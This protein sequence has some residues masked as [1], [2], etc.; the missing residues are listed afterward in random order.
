MERFK[1]CAH[2]FARRSI[3]GPDAVHNLLVFLFS[4]NIFDTCAHVFRRSLKLAFYSFGTLSHSCSF[5]GRKEVMPFC[6]SHTLILIFPS[7]S[8]AL[9]SSNATSRTFSASL[10]NN[11]GLFRRNKTVFRSKVNTLIENFLV[12]GIFAFSKILKRF[13]WALSFLHQLKHLFSFFFVDVCRQYPRLF[14]KGKTR[15]RCFNIFRLF[16]RRFARFGILAL[17]WQF[18]SVFN[19]L[20]YFLGLFEFFSFQQPVFFSE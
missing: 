5:F 11:F 15:S 3:R 4:E 7:I 10:P 8:I 17:L 13:E 14:G 19:R 20:R 9:L 6:E 18:N 1:T 2:S 12:F 16:A